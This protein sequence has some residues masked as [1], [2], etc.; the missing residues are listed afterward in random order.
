MYLRKDR[1]YLCFSLLLIFIFSSCDNRVKR[2]AASVNENI[3]LSKNFTIQFIQKGKKKRLE[4]RNVVL[5]KAPFTIQVDADDLPG[6]FVTADFKLN[7]KYL[8]DNEFDNLQH[9][10]PK[11]MAEETFNKNNEIII[12]PQ[13]YGYWFYNPNL[14]WHR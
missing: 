12:H 7:Q 2:K 9:I 10:A 5:K 13:G 11:T 14:D 3:N 1:L 6:V 8:R 4:H